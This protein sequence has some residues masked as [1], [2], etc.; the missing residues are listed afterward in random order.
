MRA[1]SLEV[2]VECMLTQA[3][4]ALDL[5]RR[6]EWRIFIG[7]ESG[8]RTVISKNKSLQMEK[9]ANVI[10]LTD[11]KIFPEVG[12][13]GGEAIAGTLEVHA[14]GF[15]YT[16][17][18]PD[19]RFH[20]LYR[21]VKKA[22]I[23]VEDEKR[24]P[25]LHFHLHSPIKVGAEKRQNI[26][27]HLVQTRDRARSEELKNFILNVREKWRYIPVFRCYPFG[28]AEIHKKDEFQGNL[29][30]KSATIFGLTFSAL[31]GLVDEPFVVVNLDEIQVVYLRLKPE[32]ID[33]TIV[34][35]DLKRDLVQINSI[36]LDALD[37]IKSRFK[38]AYVK[39]YEIS[40]DLDWGSIVKEIADSLRK[41]F[42]DRGGRFYD[43]ENFRTAN[44]CPQVY[45]ANQ[46]MKV[47]VIFCPYYQK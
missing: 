36:P 40:V 45:F 22:F 3:R 42:V 41:I 34:F 24:L 12:E 2:E 26:Q 29:P 44:Y 39:Y 11:L 18:S 15:I 28:G 30:S 21:D 16:T 27:F 47:W 9:K 23:R 6:H 7:N 31:V 25:L 8:R 43:P 10:T 33:M 38:F 13:Q 35:Q 46:M 20:F 19:I 37:R 1:S 4:L 17:S 32:G 5:Q 14:N